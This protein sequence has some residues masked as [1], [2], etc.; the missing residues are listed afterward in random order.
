M[1]AA[2][3][4]VVDF[5]LVPLLGVYWFDDFKRPCRWVD[6]LQTSLV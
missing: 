3:T 5:K 1:E 6:K 4:D 2:L